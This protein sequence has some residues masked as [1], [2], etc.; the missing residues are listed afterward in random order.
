MSHRELTITEQNLQSCVAELDNLRARLVAVETERDEAQGWERKYLAMKQIAADTA[1]R[2][3]I[4]E[5]RLHEVEK[6]RGA[7]GDL[8]EWAEAAHAW[9]LLAN[10]RRGGRSV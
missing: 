8:L 3:V 2:A 9:W 10:F 7:L 5:A 6:L 4:A 1:E